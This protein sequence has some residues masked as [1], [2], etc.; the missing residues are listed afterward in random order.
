MIVLEPYLNAHNT[1]VRI[2]RSVEEGKFV[3]F[4]VFV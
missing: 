4:P 3:T 2:W 1:I